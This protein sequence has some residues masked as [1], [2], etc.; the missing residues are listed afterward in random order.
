M[1]FKDK[2]M[3]WTVIQSRSIISRP[4]LNASC[5]SVLLPSGITYDEFYK[6]HF[7]PVVCIIAETKD[8]KLIIERQ[9]R[10]AVGEILTE[11]PAGCVEDGED[12]LTAAKRELLEETGFQGGEWTQLVTEYAQA[13]VQDNMM[14]GFFAKGVEPSGSRHLDET[15]E[16]NV[17]LVD[18]EEVLRMLLNNE[19]QQ[20]PITSTLWKYFALYTDLL[21]AL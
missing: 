11:I 21:R 14:Y 1:E 4:W 9:Y 5:D 20:A 18:K 10:H 2:G 8:G 17:Y 15:E 12:P 6:L 7:P 19:I 13:G 16:I 3:N